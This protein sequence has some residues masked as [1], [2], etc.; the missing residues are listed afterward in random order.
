[1]LPSALLTCANSHHRVRGVPVGLIIGSLGGAV[2]GF[3]VG[4]ESW[5]PAR[6]PR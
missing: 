1:M 3:G 6:I 2:V 5:V 4:G